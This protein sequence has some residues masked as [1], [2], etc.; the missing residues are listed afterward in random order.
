MRLFFVSVLMLTLIIT[1]GYT[2]DQ[3]V[4]HVIYF[5]P[6]D[7]GDIDS[8]Y[9][10]RILKD[11]QKYLQSE[12][13]RH[14][15]TDKTFPLELDDDDK[16]VIH[17]INGKHNGE[18]YF[19]EDM[20][21]MF[22]DLIE[23]ELPV[24]FNNQRNWN[25]R[26]NVHLIIVGGVKIAGNRGMG[27]TWH[28]GRWGGNA[29][30]RMSAIEQ[31]PNHYLALVAHELGHAFA[32]DPG[33]NDVAASFNGRILAWGKTT[34]EWGDRMQIFKDEAILL[35]SRPIFR[36]IDLSENP[37]DNKNEDLGLGDDNSDKDKGDP[38]SVKSISPH[39]KLTVS[40]A[41]IK[42]IRR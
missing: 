26:D 25:S 9:H 22:T 15:F 21:R 42:N 32:L 24:E 35:D 36:V 6:T 2:Q 20:Y 41:Y 28:A 8:N 7:A 13:T 10:D 34:K 39:N 17:T 31:F 3:F 4:V 5:K 38:I 40:W 29:T 11:I 12:M 27:F 33:H 18:H 14:G 16:L 1:T 23:P 30:V 37:K 19:R